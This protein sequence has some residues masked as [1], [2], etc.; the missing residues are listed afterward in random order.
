MPRT[1]KQPER[2]K[3]R[4]VNLAPNAWEALRRRAF[5]ERTTISAQIRRAV[6]AYLRRRT[7]KAKRI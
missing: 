5:S 3:G 7:G 4:S 1:S 2:V 6:D